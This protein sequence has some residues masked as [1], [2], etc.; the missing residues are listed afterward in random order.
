MISRLI[1]LLTLTAA[2]LF[3]QS[4]NIDRQIEE[5]LSKMTLEEKASYIGGTKGFYLRAIP[6][7]GLPEVKM[8]D[9][10]LGIRGSGK[11][12]A[13]PATIALSATW[14]RALAYKVGQAIGLEARA[15]QIGILLAP[16]VNIYRAPMCGRNFE[17][18]G[19]DPFLTA[20]MAVQYIKG[21][22]SNKVAAT[23]KHFAANNQ[24]YDRHWVGSNVDERTLREI[25]FPAF[26]AAVQKGGALAVMAAY[27]PLNGIH[28]SENAWLLNEVLKKEWGFEGL[29]MSDWGAVHSEQAI[30]AGLDL[31]MPE[32]RFM[33][34]EK[35]I[36]LIKNGQLDE[37]ILDDKVRRILRVC[38]TM[39]LFNANR[40]KPTI[41]WD[42]HHDLAVQVA[43]EGMVLLKNDDDLLPLKPEKIR[44]LV[45]LGPTAYPTPTSGGGSAFIK[46]YRTISFYEAIKNTAGSQTQVDFINTERYLSM[47]RLVEQGRFFV[48]SD[49][50]EPGL[51]AIFFNNME[52][53]YPP[54]YR[55]V[56]QKIAFDFGTLSP[57]FGVRSSGYSIRWRA[58]IKPEK[59]GKY[60]FA[61]ESDD[62]VRV[63][64]DGTLIIDN[65]TD[66]AVQKDVKEVRLVAGKVYDLR[67]EYYNNKGQGLIRFGYGLIDET[68]LAQKL[69]RVKEYDAAIV[70]VGFNSEL[71]GEGHDRPFSLPQ[72][73]VDL[74]QQVARRNSNTIVLLTAGGGVD[75]LPWIK[76]AKAVLHA[77]YPGQAG[78][79]PAADILFGKVNP[80]GKLP[81]TIEKRLQ[82][83]AAFN[84]YYPAAVDTPVYSADFSGNPQNVD[85]GEG[86]FL[87]YRH[88]DKYDLEPLFPFGFG[89]SYTRFD[90]DDLELSGKVMLPDGRLT[91]RCKITNKGKMAG[92]EVVQL[93][94][95]KEVDVV[96][97]EKA[98]KG[99]Q[100]VKLQ[101]GES[102]IIEFE[103]LPEH[104]QVFDHLKKQWEVK[105]GKYQ[106]LIGASSRDIRLK[107]KFLVKP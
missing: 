58:Y 69:A 73:Q 46:P 20:E 43:R 13:F 32:A 88:F 93:Y 8:S 78:G 77:F 28:C 102:K 40:S 74:I 31:E 1:F 62:G 95:K 47:D 99:F 89:L 34:A 104:F 60:V 35:I 3:S 19:E 7:L 85:Y 55:R 21:V 5:L 71:E 81:F 42:E 90:F 75:F 50:S 65:W 14:N 53:R 6:R 26:K 94:L 82:D 44:S 33:T 11:S 92:A 45:V 27:N 10:P 79:E 23:V 61:T 91:V 107:G 68:P 84:Y 16:A 56:D 39:D 63:Y 29:V 17:Y 105:A 86:I 36:A 66:H 100:K 97:V 25:Y 52:L 9:G 106:V 87:G 57:A 48:D 15:K 103:I 98:L 51:K 54:I 76:K 4:A 67:L 12:T 70:C 24:E 96:T 2:T 101:P 38:L 80:S 41:D 49:L 64:L 72:K 83:G 37:K 22:Q 30:E 18:F 59:T